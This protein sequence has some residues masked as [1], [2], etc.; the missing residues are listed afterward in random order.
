MRFQWKYVKKL[1]KTPH[2]SDIFR[3]Y[4]G[5]KRAKNLAHRGRFTYILKSTYNMPANRILGSG[6]KTF[7]ENVEKPPKLPIWPILVIK[8]PW[9]NLNTYTNKTSSNVLINKVSC[10]SGENFQENR[11]KPT[12]WHIS[13]LFGAKKGPKIWPTEVIFHIHLKVPTICL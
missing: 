10:D 3:L 9:K 1:D 2:I 13:A 4:L 11:R 7:W 12:Y 5:L 6:I 8:N